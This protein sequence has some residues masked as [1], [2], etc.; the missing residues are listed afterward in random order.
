MLQSKKDP[1]Q[2]GHNYYFVM[3]FWGIVYCISIKTRISKLKCMN[4][5]E[6]NLI[7]ATRTTFFEFL[8]YGLI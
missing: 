8:S 7:L 1:C 5:A 6:H 4:L 2:N 3:H